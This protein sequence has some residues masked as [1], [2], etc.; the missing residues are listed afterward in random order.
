MYCPLSH[1]S[2]PGLNET[3]AFLMESDAGTLLYYLDNDLIGNYPSILLHLNACL[4]RPSKQF[5]NNKTWAALIKPYRTDPG[6]TSKHERI[7]VHNTPPKTGTQQQVSPG[8]IIRVKLANIGDKCARLP[9][10]TL[11]ELARQEEQGLGDQVGIRDDFDAVLR[12]AE[13]VDGRAPTNAGDQVSFCA[14]MQTRT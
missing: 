9:V 3:S 1:P 11:K 13:T 2:I 12:H 6:P 4:G 5:R 14:R 10:E 8:L 7:T